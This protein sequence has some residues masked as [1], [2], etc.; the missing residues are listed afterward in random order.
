MKPGETCY[1]LTAR[2]ESGDDFGPFVFASPPSEEQ[3]EKFFRD[4]CPAEFDDGEGPG[5][6][7][8]F[9]NEVCLHTRKVESLP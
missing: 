1:I 7:G 3:Q 9:L 5:P 8:S 2:S 4:L 6:W